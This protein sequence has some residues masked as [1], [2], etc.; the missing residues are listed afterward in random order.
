[1]KLG[2]LMQLTLEQNLCHTA[3]PSIHSG[4][5]VCLGVPSRFAKCPGVS[6]FVAVF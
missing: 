1:M 3:K 5:N 2:I 4:L 6:D